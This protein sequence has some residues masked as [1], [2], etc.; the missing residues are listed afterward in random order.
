MKN[1]GTLRFKEEEIAETLQ[2]I[3]KLKGQEKKE[4]NVALKKSLT[5]AVDRN[6]MLI[7]QL[8]Q[9]EP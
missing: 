1:D 6:Q 9:I 5:Y 4:E 7:K 3:E 2:F 8:S